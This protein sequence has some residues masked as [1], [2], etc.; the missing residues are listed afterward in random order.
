MITIVEPK[1]HI[2]KLWGKQRIREDATYRMM[3]YVL[4]V[5]HDSKVLLYNV[6]TGQLVILDEAEAVTLDN[7]PMAYTTELSHLVTGHYLVPEDCDE[8]QLVVGI[9]KLLRMLE[10]TK[11]TVG[12]TH[13]TILPTTACN[14]R[15]YYCFEQ[16]V[17]PETMTEQTA[18]DV[19]EFIQSHCGNQKVFIRW[20][21]GEPTIAANRIDQIC[22]GLRQLGVDF[23]SKITTNGYLF[24][25]EMVAKACDL[26][27]LESA[28]VSLDGTEERY[29]KVKAYVNTDENAYQR[30]LRNVGFLLTHGVRVSL[31]MNFDRDNY[32]EF[33]D[34]LLEAKKRYQEH[35]LLNVYVHQIN[36]HYPNVDAGRIHGDEEWFGKKILELNRLSRD[37]G[38][39]HKKPALPF[40]DYRWCIAARDDAITILPHGE[41]VGCPEQIGPDQFKGTLKKG[42]T[43]TDLICS[44]KQFADYERCWDCV[45]F[46]GCVKIINCAGKDRCFYKLERLSQAKELIVRLVDSSIRE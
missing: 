14:A 27:N 8:H 29:N 46:P 26:W 34:L 38:F 6:V 31:R 37:L 5:D 12:I 25:D 28:M 1:Q 32:R 23:S 35:T 16:G 36:D 2:D 45:L 18:I 41:L 3:R 24:D 30:V 9:R 43:N 15:C 4:R 10:D 13:Y 42:V 22:K 33:A 40:L 7:L 39:L 20:F 17:R 19:V 11:K 44:W 21:G